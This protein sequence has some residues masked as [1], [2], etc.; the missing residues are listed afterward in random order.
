MKFLSF[1]LLLLQYN[2]RQQLEGQFQTW[3]MIGF[4]IGGLFLTRVV[5]GV[6]A[7]ILGFTL[8][9][10]KRL[11]A[12][13]TAHAATFVICAVGLWAML[14]KPRGSVSVPTSQGSMNYT[15]SGEYPFLNLFIY[16]ICILIWFAVDFAVAKILDK[17]AQS[18]AAAPTGKIILGTRKKIAPYGG[19]NFPNR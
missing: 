12:V 9:R 15:E 17:R 18:K 4:F 19:G 6:I 14:S 2:R 5:S 13:A 7:L 1:L 11:R 10:G 3:M 16:L 8:M